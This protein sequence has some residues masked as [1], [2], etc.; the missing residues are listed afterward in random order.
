MNNRNLEGL[1]LN[2]LTL[3]DNS[4]N[5]RVCVGEYKD[6]IIV[7]DPTLMPG[8]YMGI[9]YN[10]YACRPIITLNQVIRVM[11][12][13]AYSSESTATLSKNIV[14][15]LILHEYGHFKNGDLYTPGST[16][17]DIIALNGNVPIQEVQAD[18]YADMCLAL[19]GED[20]QLIFAALEELFV[21]NLPE[22]D[23][24]HYGA[25]ELRA[26]SKEFGHHAG[27]SAST[28]KGAPTITTNI[29]AQH[30]SIPNS[31][32]ASQLTDRVNTLVAL[33]KKVNTFTVNILDKLAVARLLPI[34]TDE[35]DE[36]GDEVLFAEYDF[37]YHIINDRLVKIRNST[38]K[39]NI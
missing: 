31:S 36:S 39:T 18:K 26:R 27:F 23:Y 22:P 20:N 7:L 1:K 25:V 11:M 14:N 16:S 8:D 30:Q 34:V 13:N 12:L 28:L 10:A 17:R 21:N 2:M 24:D 6:A 35:C 3:N 38:I 29:I 15:F 19:S 5:T 32:V 37:S 33:G 9:T 4:L